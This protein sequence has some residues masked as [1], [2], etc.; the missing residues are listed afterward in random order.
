MPDLLEV[1]VRFGEEIVYLMVEVVGVFAQGAM[2]RVRDNPE[3]GVGNVLIDE[4]GVRNR[5]EVVV[6]TD[7]ER[8]RL[9]SVELS[10]CDV[11]LPP[12]EEKE[13]AV[14]L[15]LGGGIVL[16]KPGVVLLLLLVPES[17]LKGIGRR[18]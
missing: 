10:E 5:N 3:V 16:V 14:V 9:D 17:W 18:P 13:L 11:R 7:D 4:H 1:F 6:A 15:F 12:I 8:R 2:A